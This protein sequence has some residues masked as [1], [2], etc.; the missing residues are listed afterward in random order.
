MNSHG[1]EFWEAFTATENGC[2]GNCDNCA[3]WWNHRQVCL[4]Q[5]LKNWRVWADQQKRERME[6]YDK[7]GKIQRVS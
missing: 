5:D 3:M 4:H 7:D 6:M 2:D 1:D